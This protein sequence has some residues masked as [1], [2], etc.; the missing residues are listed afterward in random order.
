MTESDGEETPPLCPS[1]N[2][3]AFKGGSQT[4]FLSVLFPENVFHSEKCFRAEITRI[5][6][7]DD[8][9]FGD[10]KVEGE[11]FFFTSHCVV[12]IISELH[13]SVCDFH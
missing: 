13:S 6:P 4:S 3:S 11:A 8:E 2:C 9:A 1:R 7:G 12:H 5:Y 10:G